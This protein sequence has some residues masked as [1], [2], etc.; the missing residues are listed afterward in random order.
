M[1]SM[2]NLH[3]IWISLIVLI[4]IFWS[5]WRIFNN[6]RKKPNDDKK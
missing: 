5:S 6:K 4:P 2:N 1:E 3:L